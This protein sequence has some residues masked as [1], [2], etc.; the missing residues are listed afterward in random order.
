MKTRRQAMQS[1]AAA[2]VALPVLNAQAHKHTAASA[3]S[4]RPYRAKWLTAAERKLLAETCDIFLPGAAEARV[5]EYIDYA[6]HTDATRQKQLREGLR[7]IAKTRPAGRTALLTEASE[8]LESPQG[9]HFT[10]FKDLTIDAYYQTR[11]G[12]VEELGWNGNT[13][14][15]EFKGCTHPEHQ[16]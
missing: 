13:Y 14:L 10:L 5:E 11:E 6:L 4:A 3:S 2:A 8:Q 15:P 7:W 16:G 9:R 1:A 12:L